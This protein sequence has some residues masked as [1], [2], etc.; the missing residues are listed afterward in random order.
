MIKSVGIALGFICYSASF[1]FGQSDT[2]TDNKPGYIFLNYTNDYFN[3]EDRYYTQGIQLEVQ[4][5]SIAKS[6][7]RKILIK[8]KN[9]TSSAH[10]LFIK[11]EAFTPTSIRSEDILYGDH[12]FGCALFIG[13]NRVSLNG[14]KKVKVTSNITVGMIGDIGKCEE[15]QTGIH[16]ATGNRLPFGWGNQLSRDLVLNYRLRFEKGFL[17]K[18]HLELLA[19]S[20]ARFGT[21]HNDLQIGISTRVGKI[22]SFFTIINQHKKSKINL[23]MSGEV[24]IEGVGYNASMQGGIFSNSLYTVPSSSVT[25]LI[26]GANASLALTFKRW[27]ITHYKTWR[28]SAFKDASNHGWGYLQIQHY[29]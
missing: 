26:Y 19:F 16:A 10:G 1:C 22:Q 13:E 27:S 8:V 9:E 6:P 15:I 4:L 3:A 25:R 29:F 17:S 14:D 24:Y 20:D 7:V 21:Y 28:T 18:K 2:I 5:P 12:P 11:H 23:Y